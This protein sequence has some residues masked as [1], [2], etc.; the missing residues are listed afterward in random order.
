MVP[1]QAVRTS[2]R[3]ACLFKYRGEYN[4]DCQRL[5]TV[6]Y[7]PKFRKANT[8][9]GRNKEE[10]ILKSLLNH[11]DFFNAAIQRHEHWINEVSDPEIENAHL[12]IIGLIRQ[13]REKCVSLIDKY[14]GHNK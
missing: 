6:A 10:A 4:V 8:M 1:L 13:T 12:E 14:K 5:S 11:L 7:E 3:T 9:F 2:Q